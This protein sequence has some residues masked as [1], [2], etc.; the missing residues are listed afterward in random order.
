M[1]LSVW[2]RELVSGCTCSLSAG[3][4]AGEGPRVLQPAPGPA[5]GSGCSLGP[6]TPVSRRM[7]VSGGFSTGGWDSAG[8]P[9][10]S[11]ELVHWKLLYHMA[12]A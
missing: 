8:S 9:S 2:R 7:A 12:P 3:G 10:H 11:Y 1:L 6:Q 5:A 4:G